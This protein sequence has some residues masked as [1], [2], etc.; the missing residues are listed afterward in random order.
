MVPEIFRR[1]TAIATAAGLLLAVGCT[2]KKQ[3]AP[4]LTGPSELGTSVIV[5]V[6]PDTLQQDGASQS[7]VTVT[8]RDTAG[9]PKAN[10]PMRAEITV[11]G[12]TTDFGSL[13]ARN[14]VTDSS[15]KATLIYTAPPA[16]PLGAN[17]NIIVGIQVTP[18]GTDFGNAY[19]RSASIR[20]VPP[21]IVGPPPSPLL[22][23]FTAPSATT[24]NPSVFTATVTDSAGNDAT[25]Q[26]ASYSWDF[27]DGDTAGGQT[28]THAYS[29]PG[30]F[31]VTLTIT[32]LLGRVA[33][34]TRT[35][36]VGPGTLPTATFVFSPTPVQAGQTVNFNASGSTAEPGHR[37][38]TFSWNF[39][40]GTLVETSGPI[41]TH[42][43]AKT[44]TYTVTLKVTDD[45]GRK[46][47]LVSQAITVL[48]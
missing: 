2:M 8:A 35:V 33:H 11:A 36:T 17:T 1:G 24:G 14:I 13:S 23:A 3:E 19:P 34:A 27:G 45:A 40:D 25:S 38:T 41:A 31:A 48:P 12:V 18:T 37:L 30:S 6:S 43:F 5:Q 42:V 20:L 4:P 9:Q 15:G 21:G 29:S 22:P 39:G 16:P 28:A 47:S 10:V 46:S 26:V 44:G 32:D 7:L